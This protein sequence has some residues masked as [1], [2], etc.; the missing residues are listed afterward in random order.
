MLAGA[1]ET[2]KEEALMCTG[3]AQHLRP[4]YLL[5]LAWGWRVLMGVRTKVGAARC[6]HPCCPP[7]AFS[8]LSLMDLRGLG[9]EARLSAKVAVWIYESGSR[10]Q[11]SNQSPRSLGVVWGCVC[12]QRGWGMEGA[13][14]LRLPGGKAWEN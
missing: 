10:A 13:G 11:M 5:L 2:G 6:L 7:E 14:G 3:P 4:L 1:L 12:V 9:G 8:P